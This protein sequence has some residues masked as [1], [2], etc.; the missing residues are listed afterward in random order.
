MLKTFFDIAA[1]NREPPAANNPDPDDM[2]I[3]ANMNAPQPQNLRHPDTS[4]ASF[5]L[6]LE[7][8]GRPSRPPT[9]EQNIAKKCNAEIVTLMLLD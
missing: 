5:L 1:V 6:F 8:H 2:Q 3:P 9:D 7:T 4:L